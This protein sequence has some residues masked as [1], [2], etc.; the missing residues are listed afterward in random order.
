MSG[1]GAD[2]IDAILEGMPTLATQIRYTVAT[3][4]NSELV[5]IVTGGLST[6][7]EHARVQTDQGLYNGAD[8]IVR[9][10]T[11]DEPAAWSADNALCGQVVEILLYGQTAWK[12]VRVHGR[13][14]M[15]GGVRLN[16]SAEFANG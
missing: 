12:R 15:D 5:G 6:G 16:V 10:K 13:R 8:G 2:A 3:G 14:E 7:L 11:S 1:L 4:T 9:Y